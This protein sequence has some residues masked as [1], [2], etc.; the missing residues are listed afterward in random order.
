[1]SVVRYARRW[2][3]LR[4]MAVLKFFWEEFLIPLGHAMVPGV[5]DAVTVF[6]PVAVATGQLTS[7][8]CVAAV[9]PESSPLS[10]ELSPSTKYSSGPRLIGLAG[11]PWVAN[12]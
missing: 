11:V 7:V 12:A 10:G 8:T 2:L 3:A 9:T 5:S 1:M 6:A 4:G